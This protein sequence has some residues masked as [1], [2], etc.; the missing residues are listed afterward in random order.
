LLDRAPPEIWS[1]IDRLW[2]SR[3]PGVALK[4]ED[5]EI[6]ER[7]Q[8][9]GVELWMKESPQFRLTVLNTAIEDPAKVREIYRQCELSHVWSCHVVHEGRYYKCS[10]APLTSARLSLVG[11]AFDNRE[12]DGVALHDEPNLLERLGNYLA[13][14][15]PLAA[16]T[17]CLGSRGPHIPVKQ[18][19]RKGLQ[20][21]LAEDHSRAVELVELPEHADGQVLSSKPPVSTPPWWPSALK[22]D[23][24]E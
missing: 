2:I 5:A 10:P 19:N 13:D 6:Q 7:A 3:Y 9:A 21:W 20:A 16:C 18:L 15:R 17:Y 22:E 8:Q 14:E 11:V 4:L 1:V 23:R 24:F 12:Q